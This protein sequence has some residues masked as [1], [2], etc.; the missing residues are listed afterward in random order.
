MF[1]FTNFISVTVIIGVLTRISNHFFCK[2]YKKIYIYLTPFLIIIAVFPLASFIVGF[3][4]VV[5]EYLLALILWF[6]FDMVRK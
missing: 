3:D 4:V 1:I 6:F 2:K 5:S